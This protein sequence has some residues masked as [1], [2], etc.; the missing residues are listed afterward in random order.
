M[1][2]E[3]S[4]SLDRADLVNVA[5]K[6][7]QCQIDAVKI[8]A[9]KT[10]LDNIDPAKIDPAKIDAAKTECDKID[11]AKD[12]SAEAAPDKSQ[13]ASE[14]DDADVVVDLDVYELPV[15]G[16]GWGPDD[17]SPDADVV[18]AAEDKLA[19]RSLGLVSFLDFFSSRSGKIPA[20]LGGTNDN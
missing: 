17:C 1:S 4:S 7:E 15:T 18:D 8:D 20:S 11:S 5:A 6:T 13:D 19:T 2:L 10:E 3:V 14:A 12:E 16:D 9:A